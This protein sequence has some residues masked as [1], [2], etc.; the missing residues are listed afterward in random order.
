MRMRAPAGRTCGGGPCWSARIDSRFFREPFV[1]KLAYDDD[2][3]SV[4]GL[5]HVDI[6]PGPAGHTR[7]AV[8]GGGSNLELPALP[9]TPTLRV[10]LQVENGEC[11][12]A[13]FAEG[14]VERNDATQFR[15]HGTAP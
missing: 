2:A 7:M 1:K 11:W 10:Q 9:L 4:D 6:R 13:T 14:G 8:K 3:G 12:E 5:T 15:A